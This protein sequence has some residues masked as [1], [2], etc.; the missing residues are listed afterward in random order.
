MCCLGMRSLLYI[1]ARRILCS[2]DVTT[3]HFCVPHL[4]LHCSDV[5]CH[6]Q[7][8]KLP[9]YII[10]RY[11]CAMLWRAWRCL[12]IHIGKGWPSCNILLT[13]NKPWWHAWCNVDVPTIPLY[14]IYVPCY[15]SPSVTYWGEDV[16]QGSI[17]VMSWGD[18]VHWH[19]DIFRSF[20]NDMQT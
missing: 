12:R 13:H 1:T 14:S 8:S 5:G 3:C 17:P 7:C 19:S 9:G 6:F 4:S 18:H 16:R 11:K 2:V 15:P 10:C 20:T